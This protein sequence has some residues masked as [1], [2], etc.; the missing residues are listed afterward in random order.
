MKEAVDNFKKVHKNSFIYKNRICA[1]KK[2]KIN[3]IEQITKLNKLDCKKLLNK[4]VN[5]IKTIKIV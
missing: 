1:Y 4:D 2:V 3:N 5:F